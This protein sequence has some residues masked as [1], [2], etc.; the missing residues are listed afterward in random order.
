MLVCCS[1]AGVVERVGNGNIGPAVVGGYELSLSNPTAQQA[2]DLDLDTPQVKRFVQIEVTQV[3]NPQRIPL[4]F[5]V[6]FQPTRGE[7]IYLGSFSLFPPDNPGKFIVATQGKLKAG[8][9]VSVTLVPLQRVSGGEEI[10]V[11][12]K[13]LSLLAD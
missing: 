5:D 12:L 8:G 3:S 10:R 6:N 2:I 13:H 1:A 4:S 7:K 11:H 9:V